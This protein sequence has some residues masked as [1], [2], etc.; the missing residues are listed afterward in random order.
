MSDGEAATGRRSRCT[1]L[2]LGGRHTRRG[3]RLALSARSERRRSTGSTKKAMLI[4]AP[5]PSR[6]SPSARPATAAAQF[7][8]RGVEQS[9]YVMHVR[10]VPESIGI[11][12]GYQSRKSE[13]G[14]SAMIGAM[15]I[16][17]LLNYHRDAFG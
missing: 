9:T 7:R 15:M 10:G 6:R 17:L 14:K 13:K 12:E 8:S 3:A 11:H 16:A 4:A 2:A 1:C 5:R